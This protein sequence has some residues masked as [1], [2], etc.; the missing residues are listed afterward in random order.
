MVSFG[1]LALRAAAMAA[2]RR[3]LAAGSGWPCLAAVVSSRMIF[4]KRR[5]RRASWA[6][7][8]TLMFLNCEW[9]AISES[10][11]IPANQGARFYHIRWGRG[12]C[13]RLYPRKSVIFKALVAALSQRVSSQLENCDSADDC[14]SLH[15]HLRPLIIGSREQ[16]SISI[17]CHGNRGM[18]HGRLDSLRRQAL[19]NQKTRVPMPQGVESVAW[20]YVASPPSGE[21]TGRPIPPAPSTPPTTL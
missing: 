1:M 21:S 20:P 16:M 2:R 5:P 9:P 19:V 12:Q 13:V 3:G 14:R 11:L 15:A 4:V 17:E 18:A 7:L 8:R 10:V 6:P